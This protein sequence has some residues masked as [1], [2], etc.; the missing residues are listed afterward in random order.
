VGEGLSARALR[1]A[2]G[3][4]LPEHLVPSAFAFVPGLPLTP[5]RKLD[6]R[7]LAR[8]MPERQEE[9]YAAP[10][11]PVEEVLAGI[12]SEVLGVERVGA[13][14]GFFALGGHSL[15]A[16]Q[17]VSRVRE[18]F[19]VEL[20]LA[21]LFAAPTLAGLAARVEAARAAG[22]AAAPPIEPADRGAPLPLSSSQ[23]R[24]WFLEQLEPG[25]TAYNL[26]LA[27][28]LAG[29]LDPA[30]LA[31][32]LAAVV[33]R[34]EALRTT[35]TV[36]DGRP[37]QGVSPL[38]LATPVVDLAGLARV[39]AEAARLAA[40]LAARPFDLARG[41][42]VR[43]VLLRLGAVEHLLVLTLHH[44][45]ADGWSMGVLFG[46]LAALY[47]ACLARRPSPL[48]PLPVQ[49][50]DYAVWQ[51]RWLDG[52][53]LA[54]QLAW[55]RRRL[56]EVPPLD[57]PADR[58][59]PAVRSA[60]GAGLVIALPA[61]L[62]ARLAALARRS[63]ATP[64]MVLLAG[65]A[66][67]LARHAGQ[68]DFAV[69]TPVANRGR[70][71]VEG[72]I[73][74]FLNTL[75]LRCEVAAAR[76]FR[77]QLAAARTE[78]LGAYAHQD[79][80]F[81]RLVEEL[82]P[83]RD[84]SRTPLFQVMLILQSA[85]LPAVELPGLALAAVEVDT[86]TAKFDLALSLRDTGEGLAGLV[87]YATDLFDRTTVARLV[88][89]LETLLAAAAADP[90][91]PLAALPLL[92]APERAQLL[93]EWNDTGA[94]YAG[95]PLLHALVQEQ[96]SRTP[97][98]VA[99]ESAAGALSYAALVA[100][101]A[102][103]ARRLR[104]LGVGPEVPVALHAM[105]SLELVVA[106]LA[107][108]DA[109]GVYLPL[110]PEHPG[111][112]LTRILED[113]RPA[114]LLFQKLPPAPFSHPHSLPPGE[115]GGE[116]YLGWFPGWR[117]GP[118]P[119]PASAAPARPAPARA[120]SAPVV[121]ELPPAFAGGFERGPGR[122][123]AANPGR[124]SP[125]SPPTPLLPANAA[126]VLYT[127]G[128]TGRPKGVVVSHGAIANR[129]LWAQSAF[130]LAAGDRVLQKSPLGFDASLWEIF[131]PLVAGARLVLAAAGEH[132]DPARLA[133]RLAAARITV[134]VGVP[135]LLR[136]LLEQP[137][138]PGAAL[139][140]VFSAGEALAPDLKRRLLALPAPAV[141][142]NLYGP[143][144]V[145]ID[146]T[147]RAFP[148]GEDADAAP[149][150]RPLGNARVVL[151]E[152]SFAACEP[153]PAGVPGELCVGGAGLAR[154]YLGRP[155]LTAERFVP[156]PFAAAHGEPGA[157]LYRTGD[158]ARR[159]PDGEIEFLGRL[160]EQVKL[161]GVRVEPGEIEAAL[162]EHPRV[163]AAAVV[164]RAG[165][166]GGDQ[167]AAYVVERDGH[168]APA[169]LRAFLR[170]RLP[171][172]M[173]PA[174]FVA[175]ER[176]PQT[177]SGK[178]DRAALA[179]R[180]PVTEEPAAGAPP[181]GPLEELTAAVWSELLGVEWVGAHDNFFALGGHSLLATRVAS[182]LAAA[183]AVELPLRDLFEA[184]T[185]A[186]VAA[187]IAALLA[188]GALPAPPIVPVP[189]N[190]GLPASFAQQRLWLLDQIEPGSALYN[191]PIA[192]RLA[193][194]LDV[195]ALAGA[196]SAVA[197]RHE[198]L[199]TVFS[200][201]SSS[202]GAPVQ[203]IRPPAPV[204][205]PV[206]DLSALPAATA[207]GAAAG[208]AAAAAARP[209]DLAHGPLFRARLLRLGA[210]DHVALLTLH[211][212]V[213]DGWSAGILVRETTA[214]YRACLEGRPSPLPPLPVQYADF[215]VWQRRRLAGDVLA[216]EVDDWR[217]RLAG[218]P[219][220]LELPA[221]RPRPSVET[222][223]GATHAGRLDP[224]T[225]AGLRDLGR[226]T[227]TTLFMA[228]L[229]GFEALLARASG[230][231]DLAVGTPVAGRT[232]LEV[233]GLI[234]FFVNTLVLRADLAGDPD[235]ATLLGRVREASLA[236]HAHQ[237]LPFERLVEELAPPRSLDRSPLFQVMFALQNAPREAL[238]LP[239]LAL[240]AYE[241]PGGGGTAKF[242]LTLTLFEGDD[243]PWASWEFNRD[244]FDA[245]T[246]ARLAGHYQRLLA[247]A[248]A[249]PGLRLSALPLLA[250][251]EEH[252]LCRE[253]NDTA[254]P[255]WPPDRCLQELFAAAAARA[256]HETAVVF[257]RD[258][259]TE[260]LSYAELDGRASRLARHLRA[261]GVG[262]E[263]PVGLLL[264]RSASF[265][266]ALLAVTKAGGAYVPLDPAYPR[267]RLAA[268]A[269]DCGLP[270]VIAEERLAPLLAPA[271]AAA[272]PALVLLDRDR[273]AIA[274]HPGSDPGWRVP[275]ASVAYVMYTSG[276][277]GRPKGIA[278]SHRA[279]VRLALRNDFVRFAPGGRVAQLS[280]VAFDA[281]TIEIWGALLSGAC[282]IGIAKEVALSPPDLA[283]A[284][285]R[286][287]IDIAFVTTA[288][289]Q[290]IAV[291]APGALAAVR[292]LLIGGEAAEPGKFRRVLAAGAPRRLLHMY[293][294]T[295]GTTFTTWCEVR[296]VPAAATSLPIGRPLATARVHLV[297]AALRP[298][299]IGVAGE[300]SIGGDGLARGYAGRPELTA[301]R[302]VPDPFAAAP[303]GRLYRTGD[304]CR[305][306][307]DGRVDFLRRLDQQVKLRGFRIEPGEI[308]LAL[309]AH[310]AVREA[311]VA[312]RE[313]APGDRRLVAYV[314]PAGE[315][316]APAALRDSLRQRLPD[317][318]LPVA[319]VRLDVLPLTAN[320]KL[321][322]AALP[323]PAGERQ[324][325]GAYV[326]PRTALEREIAAAVR[327]LLQ[328]DRVGRDDNFFDLGAHSLALVRLAGVL[329]GRLGRPV[330]VLDLFR[331][332]AVA[333]LARRLGETEEAPLDRDLHDRRAESRR[334]SLGRR[335]ERRRGRAEA[336][337]EAAGAP[338]AAG[339]PADR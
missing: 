220:L 103:L 212:V 129:V 231:R 119:G 328:L 204:P 190:A 96:A 114:V 136:A 123:H 243:G 80:P 4:R 262:A 304:L 133:E 180:A 10:R 146:A 211:H 246:V 187:R 233:E 111:E 18:A 8:I 314:V 152:R 205:L 2:L 62:A 263:V 132:R 288:L 70:R 57:L 34:H 164:V 302:F 6:R 139:R 13:E 222:H 193:G 92:T 40:A 58:P 160:D 84:L 268:M 269:A 141:L 53:A 94:A 275:A 247:A 273:E 97:D 90:G 251:A 153:A 258:Q 88:G 299:P 181:R 177:A 26:P 245:T 198:A 178:V 23:E 172:A 31:A 214:L 226:R 297:D 55:W 242:D 89:H 281:A 276:S 73:G 282:L 87:E 318:M 85:P 79:L 237:E 9:G 71:E 196:L 184:P 69:G 65:F 326:E 283:A 289:F 234:G 47:R 78:A 15:L 183:F 176:L 63:A 120:A 149:I 300:L 32:A 25:G 338:V 305:L 42:L 46:E 173:V 311:A 104:A 128:S 264:E 110:D 185:V 7:A 188:G 294:P 33:D 248:A 44:V 244:L 227:G 215:A 217:R 138:F 224:R 229:A 151:L 112:R 213:S 159:R 238:A 35:F 335:R 290:Q 270:L 148:R 122:D 240:A 162:C 272:G 113:A 174:A 29:R 315:E 86:G 295:E 45:V 253:W 236:A 257:A 106:L 61:G 60:R 334:Q 319:F 312:L 49:Y 239:G 116:K 265:V 339:E 331:A 50:P 76:P 278:V 118:E 336:E 230:Q 301:E 17:V 11:T 91:L 75:A 59:R 169:D 99:V 131:A 134:L 209:F 317:Y 307:A 189:R 232:R 277:T 1:E 293:G 142:V 225:A 200:P 208:L 323:A 329:A 14:D 202:G 165:E 108:L 320:G 260:T 241:P 296:E 121:L 308:E 284:L 36:V 309:A 325:A 56:A 127:S 171:D 145:A 175:L 337:G 37:V 298:V 20:P 67:V 287:R 154:G 137:A 199:R 100:S 155:A 74:L 316:F 5:S 228:L 279:I 280:N 216:R 21:D 306:L 207:E 219:P 52:D 82:C 102:A 130:P 124:P 43:A 24:L 197:R 22:L 191:V 72:L 93:V 252:Q 203:V 206:V 101:A 27:L 259:E 327:E 107:I 51:R 250:A 333:A 158:L 330:R 261:L 41:P 81:A 324:A 105:R 19:G 83:E 166:A 28:R 126:Y 147:V 249:D 54:A 135:T 254:V 179:R 221:D 95:T 38:A 170:E 292:D 144:E 66:A 210:A 285:A 98:G 218:L 192:L 77:A 321:D 271:A 223:R 194:R 267:E 186:G 266:V 182:R 313:D 274:R 167:L 12:W 235:F 48:P 115:G 163:A 255:G 39:A 156:D 157:R 303:G 286:E 117:R 68:H 109:G 322:R 168:A 64:F 332:P 201:G 140:Y 291:M 143:T 3:R 310:P 161:R 150:G 195:A 30:A 256:P 125:A 16:A